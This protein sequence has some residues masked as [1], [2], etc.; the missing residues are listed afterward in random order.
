MSDGV[1]T[2][3][4][5]RTQAA[6]LQD[7]LHRLA[8]LTRQAMTRPGLQAERHRALVNRAVVLEIAD[9]ALRSAMLE[10]PNSTRKSGRGMEVIASARASQA[11][12]TGRNSRTPPLATVGTSDVKPAAAKTK[13]TATAP[14]ASSVNWLVATP[15]HALDHT[16]S[17]PSRERRVR[18]RRLPCN[19]WLRAFI[20]ERPEAS[21]V[22]VCERGS[23][24]GNE[25]PQNAQQSTSLTDSSLEIY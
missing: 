14:I 24:V 10:V 21:D 9:D 5:S 7:A 22:L 23:G 25:D 11:T 12:L 18:V 6:F 4:L 19:A 3:C 16:M 15:A 17:H 20:G 1:A 13:P 2:I 8:T